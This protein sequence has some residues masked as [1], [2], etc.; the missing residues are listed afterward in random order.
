MLFTVIFDYYPQ[1]QSKSNSNKKTKNK[2]SL[3]QNIQNKLNL[4][5]STSIFY[6]VFKIL[7]SNNYGV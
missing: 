7:N 5:I 2:H 4:N 6:R 3:L 1:F